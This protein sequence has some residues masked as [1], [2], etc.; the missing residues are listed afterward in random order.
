MTEVS[1]ERKKEE[2]GNKKEKRKK[3]INNYKERVSG[4][5][6]SDKKKERRQF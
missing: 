4:R 3:E 5:G 1:L 6:N 2:K